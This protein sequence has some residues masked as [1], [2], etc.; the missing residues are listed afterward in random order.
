MIVLREAQKYVYI[1]IY[2][3]TPTC[4]CSF[5]LKLISHLRQPIGRETGKQTAASRR[6]AV[7]SFFLL[8]EEP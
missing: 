2:I 8:S 4:I 1:Y 6:L 5:I 7:F 3:Y